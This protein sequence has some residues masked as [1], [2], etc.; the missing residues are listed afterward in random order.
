MFSCTGHLPDRSALSEAT[1]P[2]L[3]A[4]VGLVEFQVYRR[5]RVAATWLGSAVRI[6]L[7]RAACERT[8]STASPLARVL[9][10]RTAVYGFDPQPTGSRTS[11]IAGEGATSDFGTRST[12]SEMTR[13]PAT[14]REPNSKP[15]V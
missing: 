6:S 1:L 7:R 2:E 12:T 11:D 8:S 15:R 10:G 5:L 14:T 9:G 13:A 3:A 4:A